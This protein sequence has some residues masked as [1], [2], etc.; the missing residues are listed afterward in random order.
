MK[1]TT[2]RFILTGLAAVIA[3]VVA[4]VLREMPYVNWMPVYPPV[5]TRPL[6]IRADARGDGHFMAARN[7]NRRHRGIDLTAKLDSPV[8]AIRSGKVID[9]GTHK[10]LGT[11]VEIKHSNN[12]TSLYAHLQQSHV[13]Q[14]QRLAQGSIIGTVGKTGNAKHKWIQP[15]LHLEVRRAGQ[16]IDPNDLGL[17]VASSFLKQGNSSAQGG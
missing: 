10:G 8:Y 14:G 11:Y 5:D 7:G 1:F 16:P 17:G 12:L 3:A 9:A 15:H 2:R 13:K 6:I 4:I